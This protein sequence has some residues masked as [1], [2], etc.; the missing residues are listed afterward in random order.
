MS[1][2]TVLITGCSSGIGRCVAAGL[3]KRGYRVFASARKAEDVRMLEAEGLESVQLDLADSASIHRAVNEVLARS[4]GALYGLFNNGGYG[5][6]G[7]VE[8]LRREVLRE[9]FETNL[10]GTV[11]LTNLVI[12]AMRAQGCGRIVLNSSVLGL[13]AMPY[14]GAYIASKYALEGIA[15][16]LRLELRGSGINVSLIEPGPIES[17]FRANS[18]AA[19]RRNID[20]VHSEHHDKYLAMERRLAKQGAAVPF[21]LPPEAVLS[22]VVHALE[23]ARPKVRYRVTVPTHLFALLKRILPGRWMD[24]LLAAV[25]GD[26][27][28]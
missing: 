1:P 3:A 21:T 8:D 5:Q 20:A 24:S 11:E 12:P 17:R 18:F 4:G 16:A 15:D 2:K 10:F 22:K 7:A 23:S 9:Q 27:S 14:R 6:A 13:V 26:G 28:K 19:F 25:G